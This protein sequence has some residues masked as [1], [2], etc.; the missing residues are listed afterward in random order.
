MEIF[1]SN[2]EK[3]SVP[4]ENYSVYQSQRRLDLYSQFSPQ[5]PK[6]PNPAFLV[7]TLLPRISNGSQAKWLRIYP[8]HLSDPPLGG[9]DFLCYGLHIPLCGAQTR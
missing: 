8:L 1:S 2:L 3:I 6:T 9:P 7:F 4:N 5:N